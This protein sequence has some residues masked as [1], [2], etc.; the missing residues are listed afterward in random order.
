MDIEIRSTTQS[1]GILSLP[2]EI[3]ILLGERLDV[4][5]LGRLVRVCRG[6]RDVFTPML[7][8]KWSLD[9]SIQEPDLPEFPPLPSNISFA[10]ELEFK[11]DGEFHNY[12]ERG[13][14]QDSDDEEVQAALEPRLVRIRKACT[15][16]ISRILQLASSVQTLTWT[17]WLGMPTVFNTFTDDSF[18][19]Y[20]QACTELRNLHIA[21]DTDYT[22]TLRQ[23]QNLTSLELHSFRFV[24]YVP[25][26]LEL[27]A[28]L[29]SR[30]PHLKVLVLDI[31]YSKH[32]DSKHA[33]EYLCDYYSTACEAKPLQL[34][35][36]GL[37]AGFSPVK[38]ASGRDDN[39]LE[40][41]TDTSFL[42][43]LGFY[44]GPIA[45][46][47]PTYPAQFYDIDYRLLDNV[48]SL[49]SLKVTYLNSILGTWLDDGVRNTTDLRNLTVTQLYSMYDPLLKEF[50]SLSLPRL[51][52]LSTREVSSALNARGQP[53]KVFEKPPG[54][55]ALSPYTIL[56]RLPGHGASLTSLALYLDFTTQWA[57]AALA[58]TASRAPFQTLST[59]KVTHQFT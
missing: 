8:A 54:Y 46:T 50:D 38:S 16:Y 51:S 28:E 2:G 48:G 13:L 35:R 32:V 1:V 27:I 22:I 41:L 42:T 26:E 43:D 19:R 36:L 11:I 55:D 40:K 39:Y 14:D 34:S 12:D 57:V 45:E 37:S 21:T 24:T 18:R 52:T 9:F 5:S 6:L 15:E 33:L 44:N 10:K 59:I 58:L 49:R 56:D 7:Y 53:E 17:D 23:F 47:W 3:C 20:L 4:R 25:A 31:K 30:C 29:L